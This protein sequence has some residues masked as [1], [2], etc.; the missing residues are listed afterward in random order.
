MKNVLLVSLTFF[1]LSLFTACSSSKKIMV[2]SIAGTKILVDGN[3]VGNESAE[4]KVP[5]H[6]TVNVQVEKV[7]YITAIRNYRNAKSVDL[8]RSEFIALE[9]DDA[10]DNSVSTDLAN[11][12]MEIRT[13]PAKKEKEV[14]R[15]LS[16]V[17]LDY[18]D[19]LETA[20]PQTGYLRTAWVTNKFHSAT[21]RTRLIVKYSGSNPLTY[22]AKLVSEVAPPLT[23]VKLDEEFKEWDRVLRFYEPIIDDLRSRIAK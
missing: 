19:I 2:S 18:F 7:G 10:F 11:R 23:S 15:N 16:R 5:D 13:N 6:T 9:E 20:D 22:R 17:V 1:G 14:W 3:M 4:V 21:V 12:F 8:P